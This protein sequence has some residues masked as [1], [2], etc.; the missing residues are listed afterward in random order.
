MARIA[1][2]FSANELKRLGPKQRA[3]LQ[4]QAVRLVR[5]SADVRNIIKKDP[6]VRKKLRQ[7]LLAT[8]NRL[9]RP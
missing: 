3:T 7:K 6:K 4:K 5:T 2:I 1:L 9:K 8:Y